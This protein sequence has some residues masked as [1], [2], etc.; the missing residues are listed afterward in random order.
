MNVK[1]AVASSDGKVINSHFGRAT[2]FLIFQLKDKE[3]NFI[4]IRKNKPSCSNLDNP[5]GNVE[6][7][8]ALIFDCDYVLCSQI[9][10]GMLNRLSQ[11]GIRAIAIRD[12]IDNGLKKISL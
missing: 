8:I 2:Q 11:T 4:E 1:V 7:T 10:E 6:D 12:W 9:G 3:Y 5:K